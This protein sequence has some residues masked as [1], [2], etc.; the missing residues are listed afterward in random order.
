ME[1]ENGNNDGDALSCCK[2]GLSL[3]KSHVNVV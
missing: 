1:S 2:G 3:I